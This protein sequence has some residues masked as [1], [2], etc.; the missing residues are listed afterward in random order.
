MSSTLR[1]Y[2]DH[3]PSEGTD[4]LEPIAVSSNKTFGY[5]QPAS[6]LVLL[7][8]A[9]CP[10]GHHQQR[11]FVP[12]PAAGKRPRNIPKDRRGGP[13]AQGSLGLRPLLK[14]EQHDK[15]SGWPPSA[16]VTFA[17]P[18]GGGRQPSSTPPAF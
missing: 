10:C 17:G 16:D 13:G 14:L 6:S 3:K 9:V 1:R 12:D 7:P 5:L 2:G 11:N 4:G 15:C 8:N 18:G